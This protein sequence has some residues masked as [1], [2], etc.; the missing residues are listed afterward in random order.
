[1]QDPLIQQLIG[2]NPKAPQIM[3]AM[4]AHI[5]EHV[6]F[7]YRRQI[8]AQLGMALPQQ[9]DPLPPQAEQA[10]SGLMA[11]A[12][13]RVL[14]QHQQQQSQQQAQQ[15]QQDPLIQ[16]QQQELQI[17]QAEVQI[18]QQ[19]VQ[20][21]A[22]QAQAQTAIEQAKLQNSANMHAQK[23]ALEKEKIGGT[24]QTQMA[25][26]G[27]K[28]RSNAMVAAQKAAIDRQK[29]AGNLQLGAMKVGA[30]AQRNKRQIASENQREGL[31]VGTDIAKHRVE[32][33]GKER[34]MML[35]TANEMMKAHLANVKVEKGTKESE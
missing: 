1:M 24:L 7:E 35:N 8:E 26:E 25:I 20:I 22:Q 30:E 16:M 9:N 11:Q 29:I 27:Q 15:Q 18:K 21:K 6:G 13:Q 14:Q 31:R 2:Q 5:A 28:T 23:L 34:E 10:M 32:Q 4:Q 3:A 19:E 17:R 12:A 33:R